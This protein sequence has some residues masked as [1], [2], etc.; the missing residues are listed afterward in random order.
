MAENELGILKRGVQSQERGDVVVTKLLRPLK[1][2]TVPVVR[3]VHGKNPGSKLRGVTGGW[4]SMA[5]VAPVRM[6]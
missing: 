1:L 4:L 6:Y 5:G 3:A 2:S